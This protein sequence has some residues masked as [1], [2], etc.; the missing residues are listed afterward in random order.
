ML[1]RQVSTSRRIDDQGGISLLLLTVVIITFLISTPLL[2]LGG[3]FCKQVSLSN[4]ADLVAIGA[5]TQFLADQ[6]KPC[7]VAK[8][9]AKQNY[10]ELVEC[11]DQDLSVAVKVAVSA[12]N[13]IKRIGVAT[14]TARAKAGL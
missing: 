2:F 6:P 14:L 7:E 11:Q 1:T 8:K 4:S 12:P 9:I 10:V 13:F 5:A 3:A